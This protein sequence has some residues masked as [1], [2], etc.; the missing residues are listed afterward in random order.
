MAD[1]EQSTQIALF[2]GREIRK[3]IHNNE[4]WFVINDVIQALADSK[5][6]SQYFKRMKSRDPELKNLAEQR[7]RYNLYHPFDW[8][9]I[10]PAAN[11]KLIAGILKGFSDSYNPFPARKQSLLSD[12]LPRWAMSGFRKS[13]IL[14]WQPNE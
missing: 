8:K 10:P 7:G 13:S 2:K 12:G 14:N 4:W 11:K 1:A 9:L 3:T 5:D 6:P